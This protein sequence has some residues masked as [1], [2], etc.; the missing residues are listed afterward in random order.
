MHPQFIKYPITWE[1]YINNQPI[2]IIQKSSVSKFK[3]G[4]EFKN[5]PAKYSYMEN[6][7]ISWIDEY[8]KIL[9]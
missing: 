6:D 4:Y 2:T 3:E 8:L 5:Y 9:D 7:I 1:G